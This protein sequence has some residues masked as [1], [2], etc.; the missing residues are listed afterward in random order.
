[1]ITRAACIAACLIGL[2]ASAA[3]T[4]A[5][6]QDAAAPEA[7]KDTAAK[8][9]QFTTAPY[10]WAFGITGDVGNGKHQ[11]S[12]NDNFIDILQKSDSLVG[13][14]GHAEVQYRR[15]GVFFDGTYADIT[16]T[17]KASRS[18]RF[19]SADLK[20]DVDQQIAIIEAGTFYRLV[21]NYQLRP[22]D[23]GYGGGT[24]SFDVLAGARYTYVGVDVNAKL[25]INEL[26]FKRE[27]DGSRDWVD[28]FVGGRVRF[29]LTD[30]V[31]FNLRGDVGGF[32]VGSKFTWN[33]QALLG[34]HFTLFGAAAEAGAGYRALSQDYDEGNGRRDFNWDV[35]L[36]GPVIGMTVTW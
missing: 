28:P 30:A 23:P 15:F 26:A 32:G 31:D 10:A 24:V 36:H 35:I 14:Q 22:R 8:D 3:A 5:Q 18:D 7:A 1:M 27:F 34:Y 17:E 2:G 11:A 33:T 19:L 20:V 9:W 16:A 29:G 13:L 12:V 4:G 6:A 21:D 25:D